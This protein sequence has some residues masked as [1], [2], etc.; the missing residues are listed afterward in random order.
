ME[1]P[2]LKK[3]QCADQKPTLAPG[4]GAILAAYGNAFVIAFAVRGNRAQVSRQSAGSLSICGSSRTLRTIKKPV[5]HARMGVAG[6][7]RRAFETPRNAETQS[8]NV[9]AW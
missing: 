4:L 6:G 9:S 3:T 7:D 1:T 2:K 8:K 5:N